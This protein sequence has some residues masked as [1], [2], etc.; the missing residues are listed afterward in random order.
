MRKQFA[1][2]VASTSFMTYLLLLSY[3]APS[4]FHL[5]R[6]TGQI[7]LSEVLPCMVAVSSLCLSV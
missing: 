7:A 1:S 6:T 5:S 3:R 2:Q 4:R